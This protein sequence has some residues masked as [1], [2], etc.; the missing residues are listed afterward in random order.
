M[1]KPFTIQ[2][3]DFSDI[4]HGRNDLDGPANGLRFRKDRLLPALAEHEYILVDFEGVKGCGS[5]FADESF[6]GLVL[7]EGFSKEEVLRRITYKYR[8]QSVIKNIYKYIE[9][10]EE[11]LRKD[12]SQE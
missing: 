2:V 5:S 6:A 8:Y 3:A 10:A 11:K 1:T 12:S 7:Y 9:E 4:P